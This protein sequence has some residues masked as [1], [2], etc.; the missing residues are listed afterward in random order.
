MVPHILHIIPSFA[1]GGVPIR[2]S[3]LMNHFHDLAKHSLISTNDD[4]RCKSRIND[5]VDFTVPDLSSVDQG[6]LPFK[7]KSYR[8]FLKQ[9]SPDLILTYSWG[10]LD[11]ALAHSM[12]KISRHIHLESGFGPEEAFGTL[13]KR[14][15]YRR[16]ALR[17]IDGIVVPSQTLVKICKE[18]WK[19]PERKIS[20]IPNGVDCE[21]YAQAPQENIIPGFIKQDDEV[22]IGTMTPLRGEKNL[23]RMIRAF[24]ATQKSYPTQKMRLI[25]MGEGQ[26]RAMLEKMITDL[27]MQDHIILAGHVEEPAYV[28][29]WLDIYAISSDTEQM[30]NAVNQAMAAGLPVVGLDVGDV[31][32]I[33]SETNKD[34]IAPQNDE[35]EFISL[36]EKLVLNGDL[37]QTI[38]NSNQQ[39]VKKT[40]DQ[41]RMFADY[42]KI[43]GISE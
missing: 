21:K 31:K 4:Y 43:W 37:R 17:N 2:I 25:I 24:A 11:W 7:I 42:A 39:H 32:H 40:Y 22:V 26:E 33:V 34:Y 9:Q 30:P 27:D 19:I 14:D 15:L 20:Y 13:W 6:A 35:A 18:N 16:L 28:L 1:H 8:Q 23:P 36:M 10:A 12:G 3:Y 5:N 38:G 41:S 29:G